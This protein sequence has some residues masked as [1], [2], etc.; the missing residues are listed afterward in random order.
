MGKVT[1]P[2][3]RSYRGPS[4]Y[5][6]F[7]SALRIDEDALDKALIEQPVLF[8]EVA[9]QSTM[10]GSKKD[11]EKL[12]LEEIR[13]KTDY[14]IRK[15]HTGDKKLSEPQIANM[16]AIDADYVNASSD[17]LAAKERSEKWYALKEAYEQRGY[18][19]KE[20]VSLYATGYFGEVTGRVARGDARERQAEEVRGRIRRGEF[21]REKH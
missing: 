11:A 5:D 12:L 4:R 18:A 19:L 7:K 17:F 16:I 1:R 20:L 10:A 15:R 14:R 9:E 6:E 3:L 8:H 13:A 2:Y 21:K